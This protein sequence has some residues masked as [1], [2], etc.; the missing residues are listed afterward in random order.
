[1]DNVS[2]TRNSPLIL[3]ILNLFKPSTSDDNISVTRGLNMALGVIS[4]SLL[5]NKNLGV[6]S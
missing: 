4:D 5:K 2:L 6:G 1:M 3:E